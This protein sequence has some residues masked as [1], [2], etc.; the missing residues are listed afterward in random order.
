MPGGKVDKSNPRRSGRLSKSVKR[1][2]TAISTSSSN[3]NEPVDVPKKKVR[4][5][6]N[7]QSLLSPSLNNMTSKV[8]SVVNEKDV[9][10]LIE[11]ND[12][13]I[14]SKHKHYKRYAMKFFELGRVKGML[15]FKGMYPTSKNCLN[16]KVY[17]LMLE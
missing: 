3:Q 16:D 17:A 1:C 8:E 2:A 12:T 4:L 5:T 10:D 6:E 7:N 9:K 13:A 15:S 14:P 11:K